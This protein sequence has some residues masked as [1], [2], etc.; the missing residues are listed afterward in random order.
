M[1]AETVTAVADEAWDWLVQTQPHYAARVGVV[2]ERMPT[3]GEEEIRANS[4]RAS[5]LLARLRAASA[6]PEEEDLSATLD[7]ELENEVAKADHLLLVHVAAP[8]TAGH[9]INTS[10]EMLIAPLPDE[11]IEARENLTAGFVDTIRSVAER[12]RGQHE[13]GIAAPRPARPGTKE[14]WKRLRE[15]LP[16]TLAPPGRTTPRLEALV[17]EELPAAVDEV[18]GEFE[19]GDSVAGDAVG[20]AQLPGGEEAYR[21]LVRRLTTLDTTPEELHELGLG[22]VGRLTESMTELR[23]RLGGPAG[24]QEAR[25]WIT[26]QPHLYADTPEQAVERYRS[27][28]AEAEPKVKEL[29]HSLPQTPYE[30]TRLA[31]AAEAGMTFGFY[32]PPSPSQ[33]IGRYYFNGSG[34]DERSQLNAVALILHE[35]L[36]GHH[37]QIARVYEDEGLHPF[38]RQVHLTAFCEGW[39]EYASHLGWEMGM[40][41]DDWDAYGRLS[42]ERFVAQRLVVDTAMNLGWWDLEQARAYMYANTLEGDGLVAT[43]TLRYSTDMPAQALPYRRGFIAFREARESA[44]DADVR[45][46]HEAMLG[47]GTVPLGRMH[48]RVRRVAAAA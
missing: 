37:F 1:T 24:D 25:V 42:H 9:A 26:R 20:L 16:R 47:G 44:G 43:E 30:V 21:W 8:Y 34:L 48:E 38:Q 41:D 15:S 13:R 23:S 45:D 22:E 46:V 10:A 14:T 4:E 19:A 17:D 12:L 32:K 5:G 2:P 7:H 6:T 18:L 11:Q 29:F 28:I 3:F 36:P 27:V 35:L 40:Y 39:G 33:P 31:P